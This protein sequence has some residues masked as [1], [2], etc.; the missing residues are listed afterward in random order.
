MT[1]QMKAAMAAML[2]VGTVSMQAQTTATK[3]EAAEHGTHHKRHTA[4][5]HTKAE[6]ALERQVR[7][8]REQQAA[9]QAQIDALT[10][11]GAAKDAV[12][13]QAQ[14][15][16]TEANTQAQA[17]TAQAQTVSTSVQAN[18][19]AVQAL[20]SNVTDL[21]TTSTGLAQTISANKTEILQQVESP[22]AL[23]YKGVTITPIA[24]FALEGVYRQ[25][26]INSGI[27]TPFNATPF[28]GSNEGHISEFNFSGR[29][30]RIG[31]LFE[32]NTGSLKLTGYIE[33]DFL[34]AGVTSNANQSNNG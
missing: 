28:P 21:T 11:A 8:L 30:S 18:T 34:S 10:Q 24:F 6:S 32:G 7:E 3:T 1:K 16:A 17:A 33:A 31:G 23:H 19:D 20:K 5:H 13:Q 15:A 25:R 12:I 27:N 29:Q 22:S 9:Q 26:S 2:M 14:Q 4:K